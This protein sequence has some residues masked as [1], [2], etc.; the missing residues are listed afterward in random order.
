MSDLT[1]TGAS[2]ESA[3]HH[4]QALVDYIWASPSPFH[5]VE[6]TAKRLREAGFTEVH[7]AAEPEQ[8]P[9]GACGFI[10]RGGSIVAWRAGSES[11]VTAGFRVAAGHTDSPNLRVKPSPDVCKEGFHQLGVEVYGGVLLHTWTDRD[12]GLSGR[13][14]VAGP[15]GPEPRLFRTDKPIGRIANL[16]IHLN[17]GVNKDGA[18]FNKQKHL[19]PILGLGE[20]DGFEAWL[21]EQLGGERVLSWELGLHDTQEPTLGGLDEAFIFAPRLDNLGSCYTIMAAFLAA[22]SAAH[23]QVMAFFDHEEIGSQTY[24][25]ARGPLL[26]DVM[27]RVIENH[28]DQAVGGRVRAGA[29]SWMMSADMAHGV[30]P[31][32]ASVHEPN[33]KPMLGG[34]PVLKTHS[35]HRYA[36]EAETMARF[37]AACAAVGVPCQEFVNRTDLACG[38]TVGPMIAADLGISTVDIGMA[39]LSMHSVREQAGA[40][41][42][43]QMIAVLTH[44]FEQG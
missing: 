8:I 25:G 7:E 26:G 10:V 18:K 16:A 24:R 17:R 27:N 21:S 31:N 42:A 37:R 12:L 35:E 13:V 11:P 28:T 1:E 29:N 34:G 22:E 19:G 44:I 33:H 15:D 3:R 36:S 20:W 5:A 6:E 9:P 41:D 39:M 38:S 40:A 30:H 2:V 14:M 23:T 32:Y 4:A 43:A